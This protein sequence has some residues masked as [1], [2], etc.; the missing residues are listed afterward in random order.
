MVGKLCFLSM[1]SQPSREVF[2][3]I[4]FRLQVCE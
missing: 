1:N 3:I 4:K 2:F